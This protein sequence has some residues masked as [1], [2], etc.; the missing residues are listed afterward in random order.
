MSEITIWNEI[1]FF[2]TFE[3]FEEGV[4]I[5]IFSEIGSFE[6]DGFIVYVK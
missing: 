3:E 1:I 6:L 2:W 4:N 5:H